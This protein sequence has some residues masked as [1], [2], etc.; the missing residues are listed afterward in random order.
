MH[1]SIISPDLLVTTQPSNVNECI[2]GT[3]TMTVSSKWW[4]RYVQ[5]SMAVQLNDATG[6][7]NATGTVPQQHIYTSKHSSRNN[8]L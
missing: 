4:F 7:A 5:L 8:L 6:W 3:N 2:G 1:V